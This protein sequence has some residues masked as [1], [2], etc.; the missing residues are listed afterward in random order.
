M[1]DDGQQLWRDYIIVG[2]GPAGLQ[3]G[4]FF[5]KSN[6]DYLIV[7][8]ADDLGS[9]FQRYPRDR[10]LI[11]FNKVASIYDDPEL[12]LRWDWNSLLCNY[13]FP[14]K[15]FSRRLYPRAEELRNYLKAFAKHYGLTIQLD[16]RIEHIAKSRDGEFVLRDGAGRSYRCRTLIVA[17]GFGGPFIPQIP[18]IELVSEGYENVSL[19]P[20]DFLDQRVLIL[21]KGNSAFEIADH[22]LSTAALIHL[23]SPTPVQMAWKTRHP[24]NVRADHARILDTYQLKLLNGALDCHVRAIARDGDQFVVTI[25]YTHADG[26]VEEL[27]YDRIIRCTGFCF[28]DSVFDESCRPDLVLEGKLPRMTPRWESSNVEGMYY[29]G[30][31]MQSR[32]FKKASSAFIDGYRYNIRTLHHFLRERY[33]GIPLPHGEV[34]LDSRALTERALERICRSSG[35]WAQFGFLCDLLIVDEGA[36]RGRYYEELPVDYVNEGDIGHNRH[37]YTITF[38]WGSWHGDPFNI[39]RHPS[40]HTAYTNAFLHPIVRRYSGGTVVHEHHVLEDLF[41]MYCNRG[42]SGVIRTRGGRSMKRYHLD[43]HYEP[44][45]QFFRDQLHGDSSPAP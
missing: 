3:L 19:D 21:G 39:P 17:M 8:G 5:E 33:D 22:M 35:L 18:G 37:Y 20:D 30:T 44:L 23:A 25:E 14:F 36:G 45:E 40:H 41:G 24:G 32:D 7:D 12:Q 34:A 1:N 10:Q 13:E 2:A 42:E 31:L 6:S 16:T 43:E 27:V 11:S 15:E 38:E 28:D 4:Y 26:E 9:F 29:A